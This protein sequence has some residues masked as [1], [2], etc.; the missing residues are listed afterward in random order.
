MADKMEQV[1]E[2]LKSFKSEQSEKMD[3]HIKEQTSLIEKTGS[4]V[5]TL[6]SRLDEVEK[7]AATSVPGSEEIKEFSLAGCFKAMNLMSTPGTSMERA[8]KGFEQEKEAVSIA[9]EKALSA[10]VDTGGGF[11]IPSEIMRDQF[12]P[13]LRNRLVLETLGVNMVTGVSGEAIE[14]AEQTGSSTGYW[15]GENEAPTESQPAFGMREMRPKRAGAFVKASNRLLKNAEV[16][17]GLNNLIRNDMIAVLA[18][19]VQNGVLFGTGAKQPTGVINHAGIQSYA[20]GTNGGTF[21]Y[22]DVDKM[23]GLIE[24]ADADGL[25]NV[26]FLMHGQVKRRLKRLKIDNY[27]GQ[28]VNNPYLAGTPPMS[29][30]ELANLVGYPIVTTNQVPVNLT[31]GTGTS[32]SYVIGA[33]WEQL[34]M[35]VWDSMIIKM[36]DSTGNSSGNAMLQNQTWMVAQ[37]EVDSRIR[38]RETFVVC[39]DAQAGNS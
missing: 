6:E 17:E 32:L 18:R 38:Q 30:G 28:S 15:V 1:L 27:S 7:S 13:P 37:M 2:A 29:D 36:S 4:K 10:G 24:D 16:S 5:E 31:K 34:L 23:V 3:A 33:I 39:S 8:W 35:L 20:I 14:I 9:T 25:G 21:D 26:K 11:V 12:I 19:T 22:D